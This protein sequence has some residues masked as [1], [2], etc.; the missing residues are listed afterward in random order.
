MGSCFNF[1]T[2]CLI[3]FCVS[4]FLISKP[5]NFLSIP[6]K[7]GLINS[8]AY[9]IDNKVA[10]LSDA[11]EIPLNDIKH[12]K[13]LKYLIIDCL[14]IKKH[15]SHFSL[16]EVIE[17]FE[18]LKPKKMILTNLHSDL[19]YDYLIKVLP[20]KIIPGYDGLTLTI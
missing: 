6:V 9:I 17:L 12:F 3:F 20:K 1:V 10:Y 13:K 18:I 2:S 16:N 11:N 14:R 19:D 5:I 4:L 8:I 7:H 15:P